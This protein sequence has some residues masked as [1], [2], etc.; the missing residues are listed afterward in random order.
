M[1]LYVVS[2][3]TLASIAEAIRNKSKKNLKLSFPQDFIK[4]IN[5]LI[6][7]DSDYSF[8]DGEYLITPSTQAQVLETQNKIMEDNITIQK[9]PYYDV[10]NQYGRTIIIG[11]EYNG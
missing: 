3:E 9:I 11:D 10:S 2:N 6:T 7:S 1:S 4:E 5:Q 8:F